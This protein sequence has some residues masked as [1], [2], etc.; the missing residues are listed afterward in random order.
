MVGIDPSLERLPREIL[1]QAEAAGGTYLEVAERALTCF[2]LELIEATADYAVAVK[3]QLAYFE[4]YGSHGLRALERIVAAA[5]AKDLI[6]IA[7]GKRNDIGSTAEAYATAYLEDGPLAADA[8]SVN[9]YLGEDGIKPFIARCRD[10]GRGIFVLVKTSNPSSGRFQDLVA[11]GRPVFE[12]VGLAVE[13]WNDEKGDRG[14]GAVGAVVGATY[15]EEL[16]R[17]R[18]L[19]PSTLFLVPGFGAQGAA[20][21]DVV[22]AFDEQGYGALI[23]SSR[24]IMYAYEKAPHLRPHEAQA[25]AAQEARA[26]I[27]RAL[28]EGGK[29]PA[30]W[31]GKAG[32]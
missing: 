1:Q 32:G 14:F 25:R 21:R 31:G 9:P 6:V 11:A 19:M 27:N 13:S 3:P 29:L 5:R 4:R 22:P 17:L 28:D 24:A 15:P 30:A 23:N 12:H 18:S 16:A 7:D 10:R 20:A 8:L 26:A 2:G